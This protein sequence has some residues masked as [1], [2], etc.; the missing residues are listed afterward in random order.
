[1]GKWKHP[2]NAR[3][4]VRCSPG[5]V[6]VVSDEW[7]PASR[8]RKYQL[9]GDTRGRRLAGAGRERLEAKRGR[10]GLDC[11]LNLPA[12]ADEQEPARIT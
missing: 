11:G 3:T 7:P 5:I 9:L 10:P 8:S 12:V 2:T 6:E 4:I 1:M